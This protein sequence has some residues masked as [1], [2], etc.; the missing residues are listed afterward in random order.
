MTIPSPA[1]GFGPDQAAQALHFLHGLDPGSGSILPLAGVA[2]AGVLLALGC[3][4]VGETM[5]Q[6]SPTKAAG[7]AGRA[8]TVKA[9]AGTA[10]RRTLVGHREW[11]V[12]DLIPT[13]VTL[14]HWAWPLVPDARLGYLSAVAAAAG[15]GKSFLLL[16]LAACCLTGRPFLDLPARHLKSIVF[17]DLEM[18]RLEFETRLAAVCV[19]L[20]LTRREYRAVQR[21]LHYVDLKSEGLSL[22]VP[23]AEERAKGE[24][25][26]GM[27]RLRA[28]CRRYRA[29]LVLNDSLSYGS[30]L[31]PSDQQGWAR[32]MQP[33]EG[34]A[35]LGPPVLTIDHATTSQGKAKMAGGQIKLWDV[36]ALFFLERRA[37]GAI[38]FVHEKASFGQ[39]REPFVYTQTFE[40]APNGTLTSV[41]FRRADT[42]TPVEA[43]PA[44][45]L[46]VPRSPATLSPA[47][48]VAPLPLRPLALVPRGASPSPSPGIPTRPLRG[49][50]GEHGGGDGDGPPMGHGARAT[51]PSTSEDK[52]QAQ[53]AFW[54]GPH[55]RAWAEIQAILE[56]EG[57]D[58]D[59][60][61]DALA[62]ELGWPRRTLANRAGE[63]QTAGLASSRKR[64]TLCLPV[65]EEAGDGATM[66]LKAAEREATA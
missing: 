27:E 22:Y 8:A 15:T 52:Q 65:T 64:G 43:T 1:G 61:Y 49:S 47:D 54:D 14:R 5:R 56:R 25:A 45:G 11:I 42:A 18:D 21:G 6:A 7:G 2:A 36:R 19:G 50:D 60:S 58:A 44:D 33:P 3:G 13:G 55:R 30:R 12:P 35:S 51:Q 40:A 41:V 10:G 26:A 53:A 28:V 63:M 20:G 4:W 59:V 31:A 29:E 16:Y 39:Q 46:S 32:V 37:A 48:D 38:R 9:A 62:A 66:A 34:L 23:T 17:S 24:T 57:P